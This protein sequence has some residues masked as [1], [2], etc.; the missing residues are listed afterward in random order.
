MH[1]LSKINDHSVMKR[2][3]K[4]YFN[5][6][7]N[8]FEDHNIISREESISLVIASEIK[9]YLHQGFWK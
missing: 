6:A 4:S 3:E 2:I 8:E 1:S 7:F 5:K 9:S